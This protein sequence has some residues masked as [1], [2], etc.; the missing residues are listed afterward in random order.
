MR[1]TADPP[2]SGSADTDLDALLAR[3]RDLA[4]RLQAEA[5]KHLVT[6]ATLRTIA[7]SPSLDGEPLAVDDRDARAA[8]RLTADATTV[9]RLAQALERLRPPPA[10]RA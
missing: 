4:G 5:R 8:A 6:G 9:L 2:A 10:R 1:D 7:A 3:A